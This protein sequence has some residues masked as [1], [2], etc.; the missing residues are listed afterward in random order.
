MHSVNVTREMNSDAVTIWKSLDD[1][2]GIYKYNPGVKS[3][4]ILGNKKTGLGAHR[5]CNF[6]D[7]T[8]LKERITHYDEGRSYSFE[9][10]DFAMPLK[11]ASSHVEVIPR[12]ANS[13]SLSITLKFDPKFGPVGWLMGKLLIR[14]ML[15]KM[16]NGLLKGLDDHIRTGRIVGSDGELQV[17][18]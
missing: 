5:Q 7:G 16:L 13:S 1:F 9:L 14:P 4:E 10:S 8:S 12:G 15:K 3:S 11:T 18:T 2:G 6:Y 17:K